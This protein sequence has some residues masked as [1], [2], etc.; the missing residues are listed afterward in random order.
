MTNYPPYPGYGSLGHFYPPPQAVG[1]P[2]TPQYHPGQH[3]EYPHL[4]SQPHNASNMRISPPNTNIS[5]NFPMYLPTYH[6]PYGYSHQRGYNPNQPIPPHLA[7]SSIKNPH[8]PII[9]NNNPSFNSP[10]NFV[11]NSS[12]LPP[13]A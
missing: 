2:N 7:Q 3:P 11:S 6:P 12:N 5:I 4:G 9:N 1:A 8:N 10:N 13:Y